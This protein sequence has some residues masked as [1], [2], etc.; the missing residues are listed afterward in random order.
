MDSIP[1]F[2]SKM[3]SSINGN[4]YLVN[5]ALTGKLIL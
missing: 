3:G 4:A 2:E 5:D 1:D